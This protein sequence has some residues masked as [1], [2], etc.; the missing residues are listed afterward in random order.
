MALDFP[1]AQ[2]SRSVEQNVHTSFSFPNLLSESEELLSR[3]CL[4]IL[5]SFLIRFD[6]QFLPN[7]QQQQYFTS[8]RVDFGRPSLSSSST[9]SLP[10]RN[11][12]YHLKRLIGSERHSHKPFAPVLVF[13]FISAIYDV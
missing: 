12:E 9:S 6:G 1:F 2:V 5:L 11:R 10:S 4:K 8:V 7:Q 13:L 3:G